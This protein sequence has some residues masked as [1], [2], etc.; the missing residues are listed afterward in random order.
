M[1]NYDLYEK[2]K[3]KYKKLEPYQADW[4]GFPCDGIWLVQTRPGCKSSECIL[5]I[6]ELQDAYPFIQMAQNQSD[7][8]AFIGHWYEE[9]KQKTGKYDNK[10]N[11]IS[12]TVP[13][14]SEFAHA[15]LKFL[16]ELLKH[17]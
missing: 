6:G 9:Q 8:A 12:Y 13:S 16:A 11:L 14:N 2:V 1:I 7:L 15:I 3:G 17:K 10:G 5:K 4:R